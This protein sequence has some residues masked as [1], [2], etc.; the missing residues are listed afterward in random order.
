MTAVR[1]RTDRGALAIEYVI[2]APMILLVFA[3]I[4]TYGRRAEVNG[5]LDAGTRDAARVA[6][7]ARTFDDAKSGADR[8]VRDEV[9]TGSRSCLDSLQVTVTTTAPG[10]DAPTNGFQ[11]GDTV[12]VDTRCSFSISDLL[13]VPGTPGELAVRATFSSIL[14]PNRGVR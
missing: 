11:P 3:L 9:G 5:T 1:S 13:G 4:W 6:T 7:Q 8:V 2:L 14:D 12:T 10:Q